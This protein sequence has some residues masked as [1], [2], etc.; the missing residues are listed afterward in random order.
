MGNETVVGCEE[1]RPEK[2]GTKARSAQGTD[3]GK[4]HG[5]SRGRR[6]RRR[7]EHRVKGEADVSVVGECGRSV[8]VGVGGAGGGRKG[9]SG[10]GKLEISKV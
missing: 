9:E 1:I 6:R 7:K 8:F 10:R 2:G 4:V 3:A 5:G